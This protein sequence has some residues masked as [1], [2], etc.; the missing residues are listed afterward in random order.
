MQGAR[1]PG[2]LIFIYMKKNLIFL[3]LVIGMYAHSQVAINASGS[4]PDSSAML[5]IQ[6][7][8]KGI[9]I[10]SMTIAQRNAIYK[11]ATGLL[12]F[13]TDSNY[14]CS[15][16]GTAV[17]PTWT[18]V[19]SRWLSS[20]SGIYY[21]GGNVG[22]GTTNPGGKLDVRGTNPDDGAVFLLGNAD[23]SHRLVFF[24]GRSGDPN[25]FIQ[26][27][28][29]DPLRFTTDEG[30]WSEKMRITSDG[31]VGIGTENPG[32][33]LEVNSTTQGFLPPRMAQGQID[34]LTPVKGLQV[35]NTTT[36]RPSY[37]DGTQWR[38]FDGT[39][40]VFAIG[41]SCLGGI[42]AYILQN[43]DPG[44][45]ADTIHGLIAAPSNQPLDIDWGCYGTEIPGAYGTVIGTG[46][47]NTVD[48]V[49]GCTTGTQAAKSCADL[50]LDGY[51]DWYLPS[52]DELFKIYLNKVEIG[53]FPNNQYW[54]SS[55]VSN[56][57]AI[58]IYFY[59]GVQSNGNK[60]VTYPV[61]CIRSF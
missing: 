41:A 23:L 38:N 48:I 5:D 2:F 43:G 59:N 8:S 11:P 6:S 25:P 42:L 35:F 29:G 14:F 51:S 58:R 61:R 20:G 55:Q 44:Y 30:G 60:I 53:G 40:A 54:T 31:R 3:F 45:D 34:A 17:A 33:A 7:T 39:V 28:Q 36:L 16:M 4:L 24:G 27:K 21:L 9:L 10:P 50:T 13:C 22:I 19:S 46:S 1:Y 52:V 49:A 32:A 26:W 37:F 56:T 18:I 12:V 15:N 57:Y 47:Q